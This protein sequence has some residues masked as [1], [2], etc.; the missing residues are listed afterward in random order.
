MERSENTALADLRQNYKRSSLGKEDVAAEPVKQFTTWF[1]EALA[2]K[3]PEPN[4]FSLATVS[5][6]GKPSVRTVLL[7][8]INN[9]CFQFYT[10]LGSRKAGELAANSNVAIAFLWLELERQ[11]RIEGSIA[12]ISRKEAEAYFKSRPYKSRI[13]AWASRQSEEVESRHILKQRFNEYAEKYPE[14]VPLPP[15]WGGYCIIPERFEFWQGR[16]SRL[17]DRIVYLPEGN[18][19]KIVRLSP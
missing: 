19:W 2:A 3:V 13:G 12:E 5:T 7:K 8:G 6:D 15:F 16:R 14:E 11:V 17:H 4:A 9:G 10:N 1:D 18:G